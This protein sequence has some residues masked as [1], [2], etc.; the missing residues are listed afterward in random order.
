MIYVR[1]ARD[2]DLLS[3][4][5]VYVSEFE[6][7][8]EKVIEENK[9]ISKKNRELLENKKCISSLVNN[10]TGEIIVK[11][12]EVLTNKIIPK[13][14]TSDFNTLI[15]EDQRNKQYTI[16][17]GENSFI[18]RIT[19]N[20]LVGEIEDSILENNTEIKN[21]SDSKIKF[22]EII[23]K[24][25][26]VDITDSD[27]RIISCSKP[28]IYEKVEDRITSVDIINPEDSQ[29]LVYTNKQLTSL[30][31]DK[32]IKAKVD[33][34]KVW[35]EISEISIRDE[36]VRSIKDE[37]IGQPIG[38]DIKDLASGN[39]I[40]NKD[41]TI[42]K[43]LI[44][45]L[46]FYKLSDLP[47]EDGRYFSLEGRTLEFLY[48]NVVGK[49]A[50]LDIL[51]PET[52]EIIIKG[53][54]K[55]TKKYASEICN[56]HLDLIKIRKNNK[57]SYIDLIENV[58]FI[59]RKKLVAVGMPIIQG[60]TQ[61]SLSTESF[62]SAASFQRTTHVLT[63]AAIKGKVDKLYG[64]KENVII[65][66]IIPAGTGLNKYVEIKVDH[67]HEEEEKVEEIFKEVAEEQE[68]KEIDIFKEDFKRSKEK[69]SDQITDQEPKL[70]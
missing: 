45:K 52:G 18:E 16:V 25:I 27:I 21:L 68:E 36:L 43:N 67:L 59:K 54:K 42:S 19:G 53:G 5:L 34:I 56:K 50:A 60:I 28:D 70:N 58:G 31:V 20:I 29:V 33:R 26:G 24:E 39:I 1:S 46:L 22:N 62:L 4:E 63:N 8:N 32:I 37:I 9:K 2:A 7:A 47:L 14:E 13:I 48:E 11:E 65:G 57:I 15:V 44:K 41:Q 30:E 51:D 69:T 10:K 55:I 23:S 35:E 38:E 12:G 64:L 66:N 3:V 40:A 61:A 49:I 17:K 6:K